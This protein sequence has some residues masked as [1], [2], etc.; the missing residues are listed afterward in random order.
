MVRGGYD[1]A[2]QLCEYV[3]QG[4]ATTLGEDH[5]DTLRARAVWAQLLDCMGL[6]EALNAQHEAA[7][8]HMQHLGV[9]DPATLEVMS[10]LASFL[11]HRGETDESLKVLRSAL[12][13]C[14]NELGEDAEVTLGYTEDLAMLLDSF[15]QVEEAAT[16]FCATFTLRRK[17]LGDAHK[18]TLRA[19][20]NFAVF[21]DRAGRREEADQ[22]F[23]IAL[24]GRR[25]S[26]GQ[27]DDATLETL[28]ALADLHISSGD[29]EE[30]EFLLGQTLRTLEAQCGPHDPRTISC[31]EKL[32][33]LTQVPSSSGDQVWGL[34]PRPSE[35]C[36][37][38]GSCTPREAELE[39]ELAAAD[40]EDELAAWDSTVEATTCYGTN[41]H[42]PS[43]EASKPES[44]QAKA[45]FQACAS[46]NCNGNDCYVKPQDCHGSQLVSTA[47]EGSA[48]SSVPVGSD[49]GSLSN[50]TT[51]PQ[52]E[53]RF[54]ALTDAELR[55]CSWSPRGHPEV[56]PE[57]PQAAVEF[58]TGTGNSGGMPRS[59]SM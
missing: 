54:Q 40:L 43:S 32:A 20:H 49:L 50:L 51:R 53:V 11:A 56:S 27:T 41:G 5:R 42:P 37:S 21:L 13:A 57:L 18:D 9:S 6:E 12:Q 45:S 30:A 48:A 8:L 44:N 17:T 26:L 24:R 55:A 28:H 46:E 34:V 33:T 4:R 25:T 10:S 35:E 36:L 1:E 39:D 58:G 19:A 52:E 59:I 22:H 14:K 15:G 38:V 29:S 47:P 3:M 23:R 7:S 31:A 16:L 2:R